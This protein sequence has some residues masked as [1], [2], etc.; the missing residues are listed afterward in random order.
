LEEPVNPDEWKLVLEFVKAL[1]APTAAVVAVVTAARMAVRGFRAQKLL[2]RRL[3]WYEAMIS[4]LW[5]TSSAYWQAALPA[6]EKERLKAGSN[7]F[8]SGTNLIR[9]ASKS[10]LYTDPEGHEAVVAFLSRWRDGI[11]GR[12]PSLEIHAKVQEVCISTSNA[13]EREMRKDLRLAGL[14]RHERSGK[15]KPGGGS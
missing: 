14:A 7:A 11:V 12:D 1:A 3:D 6:E 15:L 8:E 10:A 13:L 9:L 2:D 5:D 4:L